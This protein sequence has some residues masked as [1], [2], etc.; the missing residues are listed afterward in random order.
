[1]I[2]SFLYSVCHG[3]A[4]RSSKTVFVYSHSLNVVVDGENGIDDIEVVKR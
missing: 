4:S 3:Q 2:R 1:M